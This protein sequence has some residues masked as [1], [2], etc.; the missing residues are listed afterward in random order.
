MSLYASLQRSGYAEPVLWLDARAEILR[1]EG[2]PVQCIDAIRDASYDFVLVAIIRSS[3]VLAICRDLLA[4]G[5]P[6]EKIRCLE[7]A[8]V[9]SERAWKAY[10]MDQ[11]RSSQ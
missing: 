5:V 4:T 6:S 8:Y 9:V 11:Q 2:V 7:R 1:K 10:G 3:S